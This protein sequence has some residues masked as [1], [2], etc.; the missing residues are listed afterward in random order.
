[1]R[2]SDDESAVEH[3]NSSFLMGGRKWIPLSESSESEGK[4][5][6]HG[7]PLAMNT[8]GSAWRSAFLLARKR[9]TCFC[10]KVKDGKWGGHRLSMIL[11]DVKENTVAVEE[12]MVQ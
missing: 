4:V 6:A 9:V 7:G 1:V 11:V 10:E 3:G 12:R 2:K 8:R 5:E